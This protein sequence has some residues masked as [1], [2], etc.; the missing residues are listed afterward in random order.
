MPKK[1]VVG[2][3]E[4]EIPLQGENPD[5]GTEVTDF[6]EAVAGALETVQQPNDVNQTTP[7]NIAGFSFTTAEVQAINCE[8]FVSRS[9]TSPAQTITE[10]G[11]IVGN[12][13]GTA[14]SI[15]IVSVGDAGI[16]FSITPAG[17]IQYTSTNIIGSGYVGAIK[18]KAKV[19]NNT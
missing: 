1:L 17:Q 16:T 6:L 4:F 13:N 15:T 18:F 9:T 8:F 10:S 19:I 7:A 12:F 2:N 14:W 3:E 5:W 11:T